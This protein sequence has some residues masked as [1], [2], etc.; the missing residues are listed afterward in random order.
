MFKNKSVY[1]I[2]D[3]LPLLLGCKLQVKSQ[4]YP[5]VCV[6]FPVPSPPVPFN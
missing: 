6:V 3:Y 4:A 5:A 1:E 2:K